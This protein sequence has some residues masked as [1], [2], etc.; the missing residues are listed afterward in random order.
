MSVNLTSGVGQDCDQLVLAIGQ[1]R[2]CK[3]LDYYYLSQTYHEKF[4][5]TAKIEQDQKRGIETFS[6]KDFID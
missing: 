4:L 6:K 5:V 2:K 1:L 3:E